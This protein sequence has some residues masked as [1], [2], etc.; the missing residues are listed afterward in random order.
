M[1]AQYARQIYHKF[2][3]IKELR[4]QFVLF[5]EKK[6]IKHK[7]FLTVQIKKVYPF[8]NDLVRWE[9]QNHNW[10]LIFVKWKQTVKGRFLN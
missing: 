4:S 1:V 8:R 6:S 9:N 5:R 2:G 10:P 3:F 7:Y